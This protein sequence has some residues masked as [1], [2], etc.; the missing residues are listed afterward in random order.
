LDDLGQTFKVVATA[1]PL[2]VWSPSHAL[3]A[4]QLSSYFTARSSARGCC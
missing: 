4:N 1:Y 2:R 3:A